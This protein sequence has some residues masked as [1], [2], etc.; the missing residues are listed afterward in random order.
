ML[1]DTPT[2][3]ATCPVLAVG[4]APDALDAVAG[5]ITT[6]SLARGQVRTC[7]DLSHHFALVRRGALKVEF[8]NTDG[9]PEV[10]G[11]LFAG[12]PLVCSIGTEDVA[13]TA[14][15]ETVICDV[16]PDR[17]ARELPG[18]AQ[19]VNAFAEAVADQAGVDQ[20]RL[21]HARSGTIPDRLHWFIRDLAARQGGPRVRL[22]MS[23]SEIAHY[24]DTSAESVSRAFTQLRNAGMIERVSPR[25]FTLQA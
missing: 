12:E 17:I 9:Q 4:S 23:R 1:I 13:I 6:I 5:G 20:R 14:L 21:I 22:P 3:C 19:I 25:E 24:L 10:S 8:L 7:E 11:F 15:E 18:A 2:L 16:R